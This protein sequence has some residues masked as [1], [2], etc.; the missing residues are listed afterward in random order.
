MEL[1]M[2]TGLTLLAALAAAWL[3]RPSPILAQDADESGRGREIARTICAA[4]HVVAKGQLVSPNSEAP[5]FPVLATT[6][7][8]TTIA[9]TAALLTSHRLMP[10]IILE[11]DERRDVIAYILSLK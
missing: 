3:L 9:L 7:G 1:D 10:N 2:K 11:P 5:P 8:M 4:C 6:P